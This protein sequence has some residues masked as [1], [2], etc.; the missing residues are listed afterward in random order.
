M[1][2][3]LGIA[4]LIVAKDRYQYEWFSHKSG[5]QNIVNKL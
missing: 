5:S 2:I 1:I 4:Y 3:S